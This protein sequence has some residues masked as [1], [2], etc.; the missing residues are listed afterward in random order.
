[1]NMQ[2]KTNALVLYIKKKAV[3]QVIV[4][5][6][7]D[8]A[9]GSQIMFVDSDDTVESDYI[10]NLLNI[11]DEDMVQGGCEVL[12]NDF[13]KPVMTP[14]EILSDFGMYWNESGFLAFALNRFH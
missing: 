9:H 10:K 4:I 14:D 11:G 5:A 1:M 8:N 7:F 6:E 12:E 13:L 2:P 3:Y